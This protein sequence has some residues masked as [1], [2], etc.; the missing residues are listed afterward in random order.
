MDNYE[1]HHGSPQRAT[2]S[3]INVKRKLYT[4]VVYVN[5]F[6]YNFNYC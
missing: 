3:G 4:F 2:I 6:S 1:A 5:Y